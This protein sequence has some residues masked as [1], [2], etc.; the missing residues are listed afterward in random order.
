MSW[1][2][3]FLDLLIASRTLGGGTL[4]GAASSLHW[5]SDGVNSEHWEPPD[6]RE[7]R[8]TT[9]TSA[10]WGVNESSSTG[11]GHRRRLSK[12]LRRRRACVPSTQSI[13]ERNRM[14]ELQI[15]VGST[16]PTRAADHVIRWVG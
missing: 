2:A 12:K 13:G 9:P 5:R 8:G 14:N 11:E 10:S 4:E 1:S 16:R 3:D 7:A 6:R 15:I